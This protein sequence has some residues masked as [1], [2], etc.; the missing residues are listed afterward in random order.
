MLPTRALVLDRGHWWVLLHTAAGDRRRAVV[1][2]P[3]H[4]QR[5]EIVDGLE[6]GMEVIVDHAYRR[7]HRDIAHHFRVQD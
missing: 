2:G 1:P 5:T 4:G 3:R 6:P 7:F